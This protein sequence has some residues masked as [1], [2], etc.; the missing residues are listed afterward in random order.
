MYKAV[1]CKG[2]IISSEEAGSNLALPSTGTLGKLV[3]L[4]QRRGAPVSS[5]AQSCL[6]LC[7]P[8]DC[9]T[10]S[11]VHHHLPELARTN[12]HQ[13][14]DAIQHRILCRPLLLLPSVFPSIRIS[15]SESVLCIRWPEYRVSSLKT[16]NVYMNAAS[17]W[18]GLQE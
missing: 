6:A 13:G 12:A 4:H 11:P 2:S 5:V 1:S 9:S 16:A 10:R 15:S 18:A 3:M 8:M 17:R 7:V 14:S